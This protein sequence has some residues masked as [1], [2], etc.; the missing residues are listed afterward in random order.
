MS[1][2]ATILSKQLPVLFPLLSLSSHRSLTV[3][4]T[5]GMQGVQDQ[6]C[7]WLEGL[8]FLLL[9][10]WLGMWFCVCG[11]NARLCGVINMSLNVC[12]V[13]LLVRTIDCLTRLSCVVLV[14]GCPARLVLIL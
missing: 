3:R 2:E 1:V 6:A 5:R 14:F 4:R 8:L 13:W 9:F 7:D 12:H 10:V 11:R